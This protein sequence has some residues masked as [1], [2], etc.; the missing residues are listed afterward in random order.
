M[1]IFFQNKKEYPTSMDM[2]KFISFEGESSRPSFITSYFISQLR[3]IS[4]YSIVS[5]TSELLNSPDYISYKNYG[6]SHMY[7][8]VIMIYNNLI[9]FSE[10]TFGKQI[11][12]PDI[13]EINKILADMQLAET[14]VSSENYERITLVK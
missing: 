8:W 12:I 1:T 11:K 10:L 3:Q 5:V 9:D 4:N 7:W 2:A 6:Q 13:S 14:A